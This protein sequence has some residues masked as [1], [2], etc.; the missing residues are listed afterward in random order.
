MGR[1]NPESADRQQKPKS[2]TTLDDFSHDR[3]AASAPLCTQCAPTF[4][5]IRRY[6]PLVEWHSN[7]PAWA[8]TAF[9]AVKTGV[10]SPDDWS[11]W[12]TLAIIADVSELIGLLHPE[13]RRTP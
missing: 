5:R 8:G 10:S 6:G 2:A 12:K 3:P 9:V 13:A 1:R 11:A 4:Q 7:S